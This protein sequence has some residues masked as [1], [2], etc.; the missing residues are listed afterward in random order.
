[1]L[2]KCDPPCPH[3]EVIIKSYLYARATLYEPEEWVE[4]ISC[5]ECGEILD[6][7]DLDL[8]NTKLHEE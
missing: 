8:E 2:K 4:V 7:S 6:R 5:C 1:M 3:P